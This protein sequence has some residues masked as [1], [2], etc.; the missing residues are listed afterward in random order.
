MSKYAYRIYPSALNG[1]QR[2]LDSEIDAEDFSNVD[3]ESGDYRRSP[4]EI[5]AEREQDLLD[6]IN[7]V[8]REP[9][10]A[11]DRG[12]AFNE[13]V[14]CIMLNV[15][16]TRDDVKITSR[17]IGET[18]PHLH[19]DINCYCFDYSLD[20]CTNVAK[21]MAGSIPQH[22]CEGELP[23]RYGLVQLYGYSD[24]IFP[25]KVVDLKTCGRYD[26]GKYQHNWQK[27]LYPYC[28]VQSGDMQECNMFEFYVVQM[29]NPT[30]AE[31][32]ITGNIY[33]E[34]YKYNHAEASVR[35]RQF[36]ERFIDWLEE[37][38]SQITNEK[39]FGGN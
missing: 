3:S 29:K 14:D 16:S 35:L 2:L 37:H 12:T 27:E 7:R 26:F 11:A 5:F 24:Y 6:L 10:E 22:L 39:I 9:I 19:A 17:T 18:Y 21:D 30:K 20:L 36:T 28:L 33:R 8:P 25:N 23:T 13:I 4:D 32:M 1:F 15:P 34:E 38:R 31:P